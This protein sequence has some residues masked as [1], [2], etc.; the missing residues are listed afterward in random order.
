MFQTGFI[1]K[2]RFLFLSSLFVCL[3]NG[4]QAR[5]LISADSAD[6]KKETDLNTLSLKKENPF[7]S[8]FFSE[9]QNKK[10]EPFLFA[11]KAGNEK[12]SSLYE[13]EQKKKLL[14]GEVLNED[15]FFEFSLK[16][17]S[18]LGVGLKY[19]LNDRF[20]TQFDFGVTSHIF[21]ESFE[22][23]TSFFGYLS[24]EEL[25]LISEVLKNSLY[26]SVQLGFFP[27]FENNSGFYIEGGLSTVFFRNG[28]F[29]GASLNQVI[30]GNSFD[31][32]KDYSAKTIVFNTTA[33]IGY[34]I[35]FQ[36]MYFNF[37]LGVIKIFHLNFLT[38]KILIDSE[39]FSEE[40]KKVF[41]DFIIQ[42][43]WL[44]PTFSVKMSFPF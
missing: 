7:L 21:L 28:E 29:R 36:N 27:Y 1:L 31:T 2:I 37:E 26:F 38:E 32:F 42:K 23:F 39:N 11:K 16:H 10:K 44:F 25:N 13:L 3:L 20:Y 18:H 30:G 12:E 41:K 4:V 40:Q 17:P 34:K 24:K 19:F 15:A 5:Q 35:P 22:M 8:D 43:G 6:K 9:T 14:G 33:H